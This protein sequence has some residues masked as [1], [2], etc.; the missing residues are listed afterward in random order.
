MDEK[1]HDALC[2]MVAR[3]GPRELDELV[4]RARRECRDARIDAHTVELL[5]DTSTLLVGLPDGRIDHLG[6]VLDGAMFTQRVRAATSGR[7][8]LWATVAIQPLLT[9]LTVR[10]LPLVTGGELRIA[11]HGLAAVMGPDGWLPDVPAF[12]LVGLQL[13]D[14][15]AAVRAVGDSEL[16]DLP[17][18]QSVRELVA[19]H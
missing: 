7:R 2:A 17:A 11:E 5:V 16:P 14:G 1:L 19:R 10:P 9:L 18:Q 4:M 12:G 3:H 13:R 6:R 15:A 8:D